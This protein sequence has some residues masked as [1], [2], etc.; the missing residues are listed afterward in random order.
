MPPLSMDTLWVL[1]AATLV[2]MMQGG[3]MCLESGFTRSKNSINVAIK[4]LSDFMLS[5]LLFWSVGYGVMFGASQAGLVG[6]DGFFFP[7]EGP[8]SGAAF[9]FYQ[10]MFCGT[11]G[12][13]FSG[14]VAERMRFGAYLMVVSLLVLAV[15]PLFG[16]WTWAGLDGGSPGWLERLGYV[17]FAGSMVVHGVGGF[18]ALASLL[19]IGPRQGRFAEDGSPQEIT[20]SNL[21]LAV[22]GAL[23]LW[24]GWFGFNG[25]STLA[26]TEAVPGIL[27]R[28]ALAGAAGALSLLFTSWRMRGAPRVQAIINGGL[29]GLVAITACC[30]CVSTWEA[31]LIGAAAG[32]V[33][34]WSE[35]LLER[36]RIDDAVSAVPVHLVCGVWGVVAVAL[37]G[38]PAI[39][40]T[41]LT[42]LEQLGVQLL[43]V[44]MA[45]VIAFAVPL[46]ALRALNRLYPL[47]VSAENERLGLNVSEHGAKTE[48]LELFQVMERQAGSG[49]MSLRA[50]V[51]PFTEVGHIAARYNEVM[52][53]LQAAMAQTQA[54]VDTSRDAILTCAAMGKRVLRANAAATALFGYESSEWA[55][56]PMARLLVDA[57]PEGPIRTLVSGARVEVDI[58]RKDGAVSPTEAVTTTAHVGEETLLFTT[59]RDITERKQAEAQLKQAEERYR[60]LIENSPTGVFQ[61]TPEG[62]FLTMNREY[63]RIY[64]YDSPEAMIREVSNINSSMYVDPG[65]R[66][67]FLALLRER[68]RVTHFETRCYTRTREVVWISLNARAT[69]D[70]DGRLERIDGFAMDVTEQ[71]RARE[72]LKASESRFR[73]LFEDSPIALWE[74]DFS[75][76]RRYL[77]NAA[78]SGVTDIRAYFIA[79]PESLWEAAR[80]VVLLDVNKITLELFEAPS[81][82]SFL[83]AGFVG[84]LTEASLPY[85]R[86]E[87]AAFAEGAASSTAESAH[88]T[89]RGR[90]LHTLAHTA[91]S[92]DAL[93][94]WSRVHISIQDVSKRKAAERRV[95]EVQQNLQA[96]VE[97]SPLGIFRV[98]DGAV[99]SANPA[100][101]RLLGYADAET[102]IAQAPPAVE[103]FRDDAELRR[104]QA[105]LAAGEPVEN[106]E[107]QLR[108]QDGALVWLF[109]SVRPIHN[110]GGEEGEGDCS[111]AQAG[112]GAESGR[113]QCVSGWEAYVSDASLRKEAEEALIRAKDAA[114][115]A[116]RSKSEF[117]AN[118]SHEIRTPMNAIIGMSD[119]LMNAGLTAKQREYLTVLRSSARSLLGLINDILDFS[120]IEAGRIEL[121]RVPFRLRDILEEV[122]D[123][124]RDKVA[125]KEIELVTD[126][127]ADIPNHLVGDPLRLRQVLI[128]LTGNA[129]KFTRHGEIIIRAHVETREPEAVALRFA[130]QDTGVGIPQDKLA[131]IFESFTQADSSTS[132]KYG[133][134]GLGLTISR[135]LA[136]LLGGEDVV[137]QSEEGRGSTFSFLA[138]F[139]MKDP[140]DIREETVPRELTGMRVLVV[141]DNHASR[142]M[143]RRMLED[144]GMSPLEAAT[145]EEALALLET[146]A[147]AE[148]PLGLAVVDWKLPG[149]DGM[150]VAEAI[151]AAP[152][153]PPVIMISAYGRDKELVAAE[154]LGVSAF[155]TKPVKQ[156]TLFDVI[157]ELFGGPRRGDAAPPD[158][159]LPLFEDARYHGAPLLLAED[160]PANQLVA[161]E[162]LK[163]AGYQ[164]DV[165]ENGRRALEMVQQ[166]QYAA[167]LMDVQMPEMDGLEAT[168]RIRSWLD[169]APLPIIAMT[170]NAMKGDREKCLDAGM[171]DYLPK[172]IDRVALFKT[173]ERHIDPAFLNTAP[174]T[175]SHAAE[176]QE[177]VENAETD[178]TA[179]MAD[180]AETDE[181][182]E[183][184]A[185]ITQNRT[186][187]AA[188]ADTPAAPLPPDEVD[189]DVLDA[190]GAMR[191]LG[192]SAAVYARLLANTVRSQQALPEKLHATAQ[193]VAASRTAPGE[194]SDESDVADA[195]HDLL[196]S[197]ALDAHS[198]AGAAGNVGANALRRAA[199]SLELA[200]RERS[201]QAL[202]AL[203][204]TVRRRFAE[205]D[206]AMELATA[207]DTADAAPMADAS[208]TPDITPNVNPD[209]NPNITPDII[210]DAA[211]VSLAD[212]RRA[213]EALRPPL[214]KA[215]PRQVREA[216]AAPRALAAHFRDG[217]RDEFAALERLANA[218]RFKEAVA[219]VD[220]LLDRLAHAEPP[221]KMS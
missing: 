4:N 19:V 104:I 106:H 48:T 95:K 58:L 124:F 101:A 35:L 158:G 86:E 144:F 193:R 44:F 156:S 23:L 159:A 127:P 157:M 71:K 22:L 177:P 18:I 208:A 129:F 134:T 120:K 195:H 165:A 202:P 114:E 118:M 203:A 115:K 46:A 91:I 154:A 116:T 47:R 151:L 192:V 21:P 216:L 62:R 64:G 63:A 36:L 82:A 196:D 60:V 69:F 28:T 7:F 6:A 70:D 111:Q 206:A 16:H 80:E 217:Y 130:V 178:A 142:L 98:L 173:L 94:T 137:V 168:M 185:A 3:F 88:R 20:A 41:G 143:L 169:G 146:T 198:L 215:N 132:R 211:H 87:I 145:G 170:A 113:I 25:G 73:S 99:V 199:K 220:A 166:K 125:E 40:D 68:R 12:A 34:L 138:R 174:A 180:P 139:E 162:V 205:V 161:T 187:H 45:G 153:H 52:D 117:L 128:N 17:D 207:P 163:L 39:L 89:M 96:I 209:V 72:L 75:G 172:P 152:R 55:G 184:G 27:A 112:P 8:A 14:A 5:V 218:Y 50:P 135:K 105:A 123:N 42:M 84:A 9:F 190:A 61:S 197:L 1:I 204:E 92:P 77:E 141:E 171:D 26:L 43:G 210:G 57:A 155:L 103:L 194:R 100:A 182:A 214:V 167:V 90:T 108:R 102:L 2:F 126:I 32:Q 49:D 51:E 76:L 29:G 15:Y 81:K 175:S 11:A 189:P 78:A 107:A 213:L 74:A 200:A 186:D 83:A 188:M 191:R 164:V 24:F 122:T 183:T 85:L 97:L 221:G 65:D 140:R 119:L 110:L 150:A 79:H 67:E 56:M 149:L 10:A 121:E 59:F 147:Q 136:R 131:H 179:A 148:N 37:F 181:T 93:E 30:H 219:A 31:A 176:T 13:I 201:L 212:F 160:N 33:T 133:G 38:D 109:M 53:T 54:I 66:D